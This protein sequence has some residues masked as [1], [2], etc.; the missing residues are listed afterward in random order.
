MPGYDL[1]VR[2]RPD[3]YQW[4]PDGL[5][6]FN[7]DLGYIAKALNDEFALYRE[8][9]GSW[10]RNIFP[11]EC[12]PLG[13][14]EFEDWLDL[15]GS[16]AQ[17]LRVRIDAIVAQ[18]NKKLPYTFI[19]L[20][21]MLAAVLGWGNFSVRRDGARLTVRVDQSRFGS[22]AVVWDLLEEVV[23]MNLW[24]DLRNTVTAEDAEVKAAPGVRLNVTIDSPV[25]DGWPDT[26]EHL[27]ASVYGLEWV[28]QVTGEPF[29]DTE[30][31]HTQS[32]VHVAVG[33]VMVRRLRTVMEV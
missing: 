18:L 23:P 21:K 9:V 27:R 25:P 30:P 19:N 2:W 10:R 3:Y 16:A 24:W 17:D 28:R 15:P 12:D 8:R 22:W 20:H 4:V 32:P 31:R 5:L 13:A 29:R 7:R 26:H 14:R 1:E 11:R 33:S 6:Y